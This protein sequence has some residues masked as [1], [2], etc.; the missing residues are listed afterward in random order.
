MISFI[1]KWIRRNKE[2]KL[3]GLKAELMSYEDIE[4]KYSYGYP[5]TVAILKRDI[6]ELEWILNSFNEG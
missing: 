5:E 6:A 4:R 3:A 2:I 1:K